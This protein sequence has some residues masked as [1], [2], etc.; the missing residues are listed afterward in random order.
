[1]QRNGVLTG[2]ATGFEPAVR[3]TNQSG[4]R[5]HNERLVLTLVRQHG[6]LSKAQ[7]ARMSGLSAQTVSVI[8]R[9]LEADGFLVKGDPVR[10][11]VGQPS[12]PIALSP[13]GA[14]FFG[15]KIGRRSAE[16]VLVDFLG[17]VVSRSYLTYR[18]PTP[19]GVIRFARD[20][21]GQITDQIDAETRQRIAGLGIAMPFQIW[22]WAR[23]IGLPP[24]AMD[25]WRD[26][27]VRAE[28]EMI[29]GYPVYLQNDAS[30]ACGAELVFG[31]GERPGDFLYF[32]VGYF[33]GGGV[34]LR[35][36]LFT[37]HS[38]NAGA[39][40]S[41]PVPS[42]DG[43]VV[44]LIELASLAQLEARMR[45]AGQ[46]SESLWISPEGWQ[47]GPEV[48]VQWIEHASYGL[49]HA[50]AAASSVIDF[51]AV[52]I[53]GWLSQGLRRDLVDAVARHLGRID[54]AGITAPSVREGSVGPDARA[55]GA[56]SLP[57]SYRFLVNTGAGFGTGLGAGLSAPAHMAEA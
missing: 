25:A 22:D 21:L 52:L 42:P 51:E 34:V 29:C 17:R 56:A 39:L 12:V 4:L 49:A 28:I 48:L 16:L 8:M 37:G 9:A 43:E 41:M 26:T 47:A 3:G 24:H 10:G 44:Q 46:P 13:D 36:N 40:G 20:A 35:D 27:D 31:T 2:E 54:L 33:V 15:L 38:G 14:H 7:I 55:L 32:Y 50:I 57:L 18:Y 5:A 11:K 1:M 6:P 19:E 30:A 23:A 45:A 53:D